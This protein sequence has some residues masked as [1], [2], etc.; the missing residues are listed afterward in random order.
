MQTL[1]LN[2]QYR[3]YCTVGTVKLPSSKVIRT[4]ERPWLNNRKN[5]SC[6]PA[7]R[8]LCKYIARSASGKY[9]KC[10]HVQGVAGRGGILWH[11][12][13]LV[14]HSLGCILPG[15]RV[16]RLGN[17]VAVL[18]SLAALNAMRREIG[19]NDFWLVIR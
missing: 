3:H 13:N 17:R 1:T 12:G 2:R 9:R 19:P 7:G 4:I 5:T 8:Y 14:S 18:N 11:C 16:G 10:W 15:L 6:I